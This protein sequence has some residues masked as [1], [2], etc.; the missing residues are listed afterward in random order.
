MLP[1]GANHGAYQ[2]LGHRAIL[3][4]QFSLVEGHPAAVGR[5]GGGPGYHNMTA[6]R[7]CSAASEARELISP[8][9]SNIHENQPS[10]RAAREKPS[11]RSPIPGILPAIFPSH[12]I[13]RVC[14]SKPINIASHHHVVV[15]K[16]RPAHPPFAIGGPSPMLPFVG[17]A[18]G[19]VFLSLF[20]TVRR[21]FSCSVARLQAALQPGTHI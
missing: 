14:T 3:I 5:Q 2:T 8:F 7:Y 9:I 15:A 12:S 10:A 17:N 18:G 4:P 6:S 19:C 20:E 11:R 16:P 13:F 1:T 21:L